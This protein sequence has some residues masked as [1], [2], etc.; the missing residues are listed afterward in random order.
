MKAV[1]LYEYGGPEKLRYEDSEVPEYGDIE[2][3][4]RVRATSINPVDDEIRGSAARARMPVEFPALLGRDLVGEVVE[5]GRSVTGFSKA[6]P[7]MA[8][9]NGTYA[10]YT[11]ARANVL[12]LNPEELSFQQAASLPVVTTTGA[13]LIERAVKIRGGRSVPVTGALGSVGRS[14][15]HV[16]H[17]RGTRVPT[18]LRA[19]NSRF[20]SP[21]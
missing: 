7:V 8:L 20:P 17:K 1:V 19:A 4:V 11:V 10:E 13:Q 6:M 15:P 12:A 5:V 18:M 14:A 16:V 21:V 9:A 3:L 2:V